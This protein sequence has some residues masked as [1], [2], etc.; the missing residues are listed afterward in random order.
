[1]INSKQQSRNINWRSEPA[2]QTPVRLGDMIKE[3]MD[4]WISPQQGKFESVVQLWSELLPDE[5]RQHCRI[6]D[7]SAGRL[8]VLVDSPSYMYELQLCSS[9]ILAELRRRCPRVR[10]KR[11]K[12]ALA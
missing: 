11:I 8:K 3:R 5:L 7:I 4:H 6:T 1:M 10:I 2:L 12:I 9:E